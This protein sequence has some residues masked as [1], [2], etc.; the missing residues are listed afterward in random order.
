M[1]I[2]FGSY[3]PP[4]PP[5]P[6]PPPEKPPPPEPELE[7]DDDIVAREELMELMAEVKSRVLNVVVPMYQAGMR[8]GF[9]S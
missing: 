1:A 6:P 3:Q 2:G 4:P 8:F 7:L 5:P 9:S